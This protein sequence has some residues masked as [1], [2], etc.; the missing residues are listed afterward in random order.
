MPD[1]INLDSSGLRR[2]VQSAVISW[3]E[4][5]HSHSTTVL[6]LV[7]FPSF[8]AIGA[9][10]CANNYLDIVGDM[11]SNEESANRLMNHIEKKTRKGSCKRKETEN[12]AAYN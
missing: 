4:K 12:L 5:F 9:N 6:S 3:R 8:C 1:K 11:E 7:L 2:P 10:A